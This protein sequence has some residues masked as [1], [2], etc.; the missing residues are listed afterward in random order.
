MIIWTMLT[1]FAVSL[2]GGMK[3]AYGMELWK[4]DEPS[5]WKIWSKKPMYL[6][7]GVWL[8]ACILVWICSG[9]SVT[10]VRLL[11]LFVTYG[12]LAAIDGK[13]KIVPDEILFCYLA[14]QM[15]L[16]ALL[17]DPIQLF[18][19]CLTGVIF[20]AVLL[21]VSWLSRGKMGMG[22]AKLLGVTAMTA[23]WNYTFQVLVL[24]MALSLVY[25]LFLLLICRKSVKTEFPFV[26]FL[27]AGMAVYAFLTM[28]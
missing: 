7:A 16:G 21:A 17:M 23:G 12:I 26:P 6:W 10:A 15:L 25:S 20:L 14:G 9:W 2:L 13:R 19:V 5:F 27:T 11:D 28:I 1:L 4:Q 24:A 3:T 18:Q 22:D 8:S